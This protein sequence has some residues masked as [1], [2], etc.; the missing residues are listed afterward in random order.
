MDKKYT[1]RD[2][3]NYAG[4]IGLAGTTA[5]GVN[6]FLT[7]C[8]PS[9]ADVATTLSQISPQAGSII[10]SGQA[11]MRAMEDFTPEQEYYI[12]R[13]VGAVVVDKYK[14][15]ADQQATRY[16]NTLGQTLDRASDLPETFNGY[17]MLILDSQEINAFD[18][19]AGHIFLTRGMLGCCRNEGELAAVLAHEI[20]HVQNRHGIKAIE[21]SRITEG[22]TIIGTEATKKF[23]DA[24]IARLV[25]LFEDSINDITTTMINSGYSRA[26][27][28]EAD[29]SAVIIM[30]RVGFNP[31]S[32]IDMLQLMDSRLQPEGLDFAKTHPSPK[33][34]IEDL[35]EIVTVDAEPSC[36]DV[37]QKRFQAAMKNV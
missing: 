27:E 22:L 28:R 14:P 15:Y 19:P 36:N 31:R 7:A 5:Y 26:F 25:T 17:H 10:R 30:E 12:G 24:D 2:F 32:L 23:A 33:S 6:A 13:T 3:L 16:V 11:V 29:K 35:S 8:V 34:R 37:Q 4:K 9:A 1:R 20:G 18:S 21:K